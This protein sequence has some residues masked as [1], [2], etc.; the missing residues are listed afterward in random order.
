MN[1]RLLADENVDHRVVSRLD[2]YGHDIETV[3]SVPALGEGT[4]DA[5]IARYSSE[6]GRTILTS[7]DDFLTEFDSG[8][9]SGLF[10]IEDETIGSATV[11]DIV[12]E[13]ASVLDSP[14]EGVFYVSDNWL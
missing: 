7:D 1:L 4:D 13:I 9:Y 8:E 12:H 6:T 2:H 3:E 14:P 11:A 5:D 10:L